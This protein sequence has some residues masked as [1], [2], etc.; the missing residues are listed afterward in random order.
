[1]ITKLVNIVYLYPL[2]KILLLQSGF[3]QIDKIGNNTNMCI[4]GLY[5]VKKSSDKMLPPMG[6]EPR[7]LIA[8]DSKSISFLH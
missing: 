3:S 8:F 2:V 5:Y 7:L 4:R 1:M 6:I